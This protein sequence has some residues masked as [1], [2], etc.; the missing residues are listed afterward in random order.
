VENYYGLISGS[1]ISD[2]LLGLSVLGQHWNWLWKALLLSLIGFDSILHTIVFQ[3]LLKWCYL[4]AHYL[5]FYWGQWSLQLLT[6]PWPSY[7]R[8][9]P[10]DNPAAQKRL[11]W[12]PVRT[13]VKKDA[14]GVAWNG[15]QHSGLLSGKHFSVKVQIHID[16]V[17]HKV[18]YHGSRSQEHWFKTMLVTGRGNFKE[19]ELHFWK[20]CTFL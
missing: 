10:R 8:A 4:T 17:P 6:A 19:K 3:F 12:L 1:L 7:L 5:S 20:C 14:R 15:N 18:T 9:D 2:T 11:H 16:S 13:G